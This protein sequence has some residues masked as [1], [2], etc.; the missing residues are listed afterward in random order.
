VVC[1]LVHSLSLMSSISATQKL[2]WA[3]QVIRREPCA[4]Q[5]RLARLPCW[6]R[7]SPVIGRGCCASYEL[8]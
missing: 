7:L 5:Q 8:R 6:G 1:G 4:C 2:Q 3:L